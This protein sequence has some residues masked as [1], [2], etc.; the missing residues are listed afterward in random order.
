MDEGEL[1]DEPHQQGKGRGLESR[2]SGG[3]R[4]QVIALLPRNRGAP[5][6]LRVMASVAKLN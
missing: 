5:S 6:G 1:G 3:G 2:Y 4:A